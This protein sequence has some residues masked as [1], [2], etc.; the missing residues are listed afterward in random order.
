[1]VAWEPDQKAGELRV[2]REGIEKLCPFRRT[3]GIGQI[4]RDQDRVERLRVDLVQSRQGLPEPPVSSRTGP[5][6]LDPKAV[7]LANGV[8]VGQMRQAPGSTALRPRIKG[9]EIARLGHCR[10]GYAPYD[11]R[12]AKIPR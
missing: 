10:V 1:V 12:P 9:T 3:A 4:S 8:D 6:T 11:R 7:P 5:S 2:R